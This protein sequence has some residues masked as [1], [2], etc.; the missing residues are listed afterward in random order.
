MYVTKNPIQ[1]WPIYHQNFRTFFRSVKSVN[2][3]TYTK[4]CDITK[5]DI[6]SVFFDLLNWR[7]RSRSRILSGA[8]LC[9][10]FH[11]SSFQVH[12]Y[13]TESIVLRLFLRAQYTS[14]R[15]QVEL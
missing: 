3:I 15:V 14:F 7:V 10:G 13:N 12:Y 11:S 1:L 6:L 4:I 5:Y 8:Y 9:F 2:V